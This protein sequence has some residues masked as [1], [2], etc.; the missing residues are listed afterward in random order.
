MEITDTGQADEKPAFMQY[1]QGMNIDV[2]DKAYL[3][4]HF[5]E[6]EDEPEQ[7]TLKKKEEM[8]PEFK[9]VPPQ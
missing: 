9:G 3:E 1:M 2:V 4:S 7:P 8:P 6:E 5:Q